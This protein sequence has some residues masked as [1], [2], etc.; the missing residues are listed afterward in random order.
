MPANKTTL[1]YRL[2]D[3]PPLL[4]SDREDTLDRS[5]GNQLRDAVLSDDKGNIH[6]SGQSPVVVPD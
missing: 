5:D 4:L 1:C 6:P 3:R 2:C